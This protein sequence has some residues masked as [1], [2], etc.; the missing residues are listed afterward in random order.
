MIPLNIKPHRSRNVLFIGDIYNR[1]YSYHYYK[2]FQKMGHRIVTVCPEGDIRVAGLFD[3]KQHILP[4]LQRLNFQPELI[5][6]AE[7]RPIYWANFKK[8][9]KLINAPLAFISFDTSLRFREQAVFGSYFDFVFI[10]QQ[11]YLSYFQRLCPA[12]TFWLQYACDPD[13][14]HPLEAPEVN[15][16]AFAGTAWSYPP[17][18]QIRIDLLTQLKKYCRLEIGEGFWEEQA[19]QLYARSKMIFN[20]GLQN[21]VNPRI[22][23]ALSYG[24]LLLT[25]RTGSVR[26]VFTDGEDLVFYDHLEHLITLIRYYAKHPDQRI[27]IARCG[28]AKAWSKHTFYHRIDTIM[29]KVFAAGAY[30]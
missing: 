19:A 24:K 12:K 27:R 11:D 6:A 28:Q 1:Y 17:A 10:S 3:Y 13:V 7:S 15:D 22:Y 20:F 21:G 4:H 14:H 25:N 2:F 29:K 9:R 8:M 16:I 30:Q 18:Y 26:G 23:E 5:V